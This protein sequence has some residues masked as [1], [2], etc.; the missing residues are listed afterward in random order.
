MRW[1]GFWR[2]LLARILLDSRGGMDS[3]FAMANFLSGLFC[4]EKGAGLLMKMLLEVL[5]R[6]R[7]AGGFFCHLALERRWLTW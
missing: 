2:S 5:Q 1:R 3:A 6:G 7:A 4:W